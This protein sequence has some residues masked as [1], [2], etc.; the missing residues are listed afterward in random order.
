[1]ISVSTTEK[2]FE[3]ILDLK[4][5]LNTW[6][7]KKKIKKRKILEGEDLSLP[8]ILIKIE[9]LRHKMN[10]TSFDN[11]QKLLFLSKKLDKLLVVY[12]RVL[13]IHQNNG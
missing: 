13:L 4:K 2:R 12:Q 7:R 1:M 9:R 11:K 8:R 3:L 5:K 6:K 10:S